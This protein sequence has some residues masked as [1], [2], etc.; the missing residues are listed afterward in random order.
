MKS[1]AVVININPGASTSGN[2]NTEI[3]LSSIR[4]R[5]LKEGR[6]MAKEKSGRTLRHIF[7]STSMD[8]GM[9]KK[10]L[11]VRVVFGLCLTLEGILTCMYSGLSVSS[12][13][14]I[15]IIS[16]LMLLPGILTR[17]SMSIATMIFGL[18][19]LSG[20]STGLP[21]MVDYINL[22]GCLF[23]ALIGPGRFSAD[24]I[25]RRKI[26]RT[27]RRRE[28]HKLLERRFSY[29]AMQYADF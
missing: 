10:V 17:V 16:G 11:M 28:T 19:L 26:F 18:S 12:L 20:L 21:I 13:G 7:G 8:A 14:I 1:N 25:I 2:L 5:V 22:A 6:E 3:G 23:F 4:M 27:V 24:A 15:S 9:S 29:Q